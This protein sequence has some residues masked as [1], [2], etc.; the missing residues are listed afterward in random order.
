MNHF[1]HIFHSHIIMQSK[2]V[3]QKIATWENIKCRY[4]WDTS[5]R[6]LNYCFSINYL[7]QL[8]I[9]WLSLYLLSTCNDIYSRV[10]R[11]ITMYYVSNIS[12]HFTMNIWYSLI[13][14]I[15]IFTCHDIDEYCKIKSELIYIQQMITAHFL[16]N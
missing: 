6:Q 9:H 11:T 1:F 13:S 7:Y 8:F 5:V 10:T 12:L 15:E 4:L 16:R 14:S 2:T 3:P